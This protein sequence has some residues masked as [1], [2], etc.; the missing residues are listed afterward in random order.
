[1]F[2]ELPISLLEKKLPLL[3][4]FPLC[5]CSHLYMRESKSKQSNLFIYLGRVTFIMTTLSVKTLP[6]LCIVNEKKYFI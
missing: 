3:F 2:S 5:E 6:V 4:D 1:M